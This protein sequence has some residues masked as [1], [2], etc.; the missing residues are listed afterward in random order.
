MH[1]ASLDIAVRTCKI[2]ILHRTHRMTLS[3]CIELAADAMMVD[4]HDLSRFHVADILCSKNV[5]GTCLTC[6]HIAVSYLT[7]S[8]RMES[9]FVTAGIYT[10]SCH[11][12]ECK[13]TV[14][15]VQCILDGIDSRK[16]L[17]C[18]LLL[19]EM[20]EDLSI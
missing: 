3:F 5:K 17:V 7:Q 10:A 18:A 20:G 16:A 11:Y 19:D 15:L 4:S 9:I 1:I 2:H 8:K 12:D 6:H 13:S 14:Y